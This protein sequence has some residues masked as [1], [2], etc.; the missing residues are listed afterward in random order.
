MEDKNKYLCMKKRIRIIFKSP[1]VSSIL[2]LLLFIVI[3]VSLLLNTTFIDWP[4]IIL[5]PW[6][7]KQGLLLYKDMIVVHSPGSVYLSYLFFNLTGYTVFWYR[8]FAYTVIITIDILLY[9]LT[10]HLWKKR[11]I[12][13]LITAVYIFFQVPLQGNS[14]WQELIFTPFMLLTYW[15]LGKYIQIQ[16]LK[17]LFIVSLIFGLSLLIKQNALYPLTGTAIF[18]LFLHFKHPLEAFRRIILLIFI[19]A[20][21]VVLLWFFYSS[22]GLQHEFVLWVI[23]YPF[24]LIGKE[25]SYVILP[26]LMLSFKIAAIF[27]GIPIS[28][29]LVFLKGINKQERY[30][31]VF[32]ILFCFSLI[33]AGLPRWE[34]FRMQPSLPFA[35]LSL[36]FIIN[37]FYSLQERKNIKYLLFILIFPI[38]I[39]S[40]RYVYRFYRIENPKM[41]QFLT[42]KNK[43]IAQ[44]INHYIGNGSFYLLGNYEYF[45]YLMN[46][47]PE[48]VPWTQHFP[49]LMNVDNLELKMLDQL[50]KAN[51]TYIVLTKSEIPKGFIPYLNQYYEFVYELSDGG[52]IIKKKMGP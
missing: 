25:R 8:V 46:R 20:S 7:M 49:W 29:I 44:E 50:N 38:L 31:I 37:N 19:P 27:A 14:I 11:A 32:L 33:M 22:T 5:F 13:V 9:L 1:Q 6:L 51:I 34:E 18:L 10:L 39:F 35:M 40:L 41:H 48:V 42:E 52:W 36:G 2:F 26:S 4:E 47:K 24:L 15:V 21:L 17:Y 45:Y 23:Q 30:K 16:K 28:F 12:A 3:H 43:I